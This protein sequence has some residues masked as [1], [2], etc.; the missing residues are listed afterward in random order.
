MN[1]IYDV[2]VLKDLATGVFI[3]VGLLKPNELLQQHRRGGIY[4]IVI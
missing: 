2:F 4:A 1:G 3:A